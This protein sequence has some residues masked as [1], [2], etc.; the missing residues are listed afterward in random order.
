MNPAARIRRRVASPLAALLLV[1]SGV[2]AAAI[3]LSASPAAASTIHVSDEASFLAAWDSNANDTIVLDA[4]IHLSVANC[5]DADR[6]SVTDPIT[7][8]GQGQFKIV[9]DCAGQRVL[10]ADNGGNITLRGVT[11]AGGS[12]TGDGAGLDETSSAAVTV[13]I[14]HSTFLN[15][16]I[17]N[18]GGNRDGGAVNMGSANS[19]LIVTASSFLNNHA[20]DDGGAIDC[21]NLSQTITVTGSTFAGNSTS[22]ISGSSGAAV[23][24]E[25]DNCLLTMTNSTVTTNTSGDEAVIN[26][27][28][29]NDT[30]KLIYSDIVNNTVSPAPPSP[31]AQAPPVAPASD[32]PGPVHAEVRTQ[33]DVQTA[34]VEIATPANL[35]VFGTVITAPHG[36]PNCSDSSGAPLTGVTSAG[37]NFADDTSCGLTAATDKQAAGLDPLLGSLANNGGPTQTLLPA[38]GSPLIDAIAAAACQSGPAAGVT[39]DQRGIVRPQGP[40]CEIGSVEIAVSALVVT[41]RFTG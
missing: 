11:I 13:T 26:G 3:A 36:G 14:D 29:S 16:V 41:P 24:L 1:G 17:G 27:E 31:M 32:E 9:Q 20:D 18:T 22:N 12:G 10:F 2:S 38:T 34:N 4:D 35:T 28:T 37:Y 25:S 40:G 21:N 23:D 7:I 39:T 15:N 6:E 19:A 8:D 5:D 30:I 33:S